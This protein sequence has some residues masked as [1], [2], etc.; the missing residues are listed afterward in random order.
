MHPPPPASADALLAILKNRSRSRLS[1]HPIQRSEKPF[2]QTREGVIGVKAPLST[3]IATREALCVC[4]DLQIRRVSA[5]VPV[6]FPHFTPSVPK[7]RVHP[8][9]GD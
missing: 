3:L 1:S 6:R 2:K 8:P 7:N 4:L 9:G 5:A